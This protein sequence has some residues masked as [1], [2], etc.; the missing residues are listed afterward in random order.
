MEKKGRVGNKREQLEKVSPST[1]TGSRKRV[2]DDE[3]IIQAK[4]VLQCLQL[5]RYNAKPPVGRQS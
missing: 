3:A 2:R 5:E 1:R 4:R